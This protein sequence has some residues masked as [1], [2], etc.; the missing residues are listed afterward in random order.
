MLGSVGIGGGAPFKHS[1]IYMYI[2]WDFLNIYSYK[3]FPLLS[4]TSL[5]F[6]ILKGIVRPIELGARL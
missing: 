6:Y 4:I 1:Y 3:F 5:H 2:S